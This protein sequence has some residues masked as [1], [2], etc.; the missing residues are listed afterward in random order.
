MNSVKS[1][2]DLLKLSV[3]GTPSNLK[4]MSE[5]RVIL[6]TPEL[7]MASHNYLHTLWLFW[8]FHAYLSF[9]PTFSVF[10]P[11]LSNCIASS[12]PQLL[13]MSTNI[14]ISQKLFSFR[15]SRQPDIL[16]EMRHFV[17]FSLLLILSNAVIPWPFTFH[18]PGLHFSSPVNWSPWNPTE[19]MAMSLGRDGKQHE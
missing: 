1:P 10:K 4:S 18:K 7:D 11:F 16:P 19:A 15:K 8:R 17:G 14:S 9:R 6:R 12:H 5:V 13:P 3:L 2:V